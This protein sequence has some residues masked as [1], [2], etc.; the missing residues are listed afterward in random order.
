MKKV[1]WLVI[2]LICLITSC[3]VD[4]DFVVGPYEEVDI[5]KFEKALAENLN[6]KYF[7]INENKISINFCRYFFFKNTVNDVVFTTDAIN[8]SFNGKLYK[9]Q[10]IGGN[11]YKLNYKNTDSNVVFDINNLIRATI[12]DG[13]FF[14]ILEYDGDKIKLI[15]AEL[16]IYQAYD[17]YYN[18]NLK[19]DYPEIFEGFYYGDFKVFATAHEL[20]N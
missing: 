4:S 6:S 18:N 1:V 15:S 10:C 17:Q 5:E 16:N 13:E 2:A 3:K 8:E 12:K 9:A 7:T 14:I 19:S 11:Y 20:Y